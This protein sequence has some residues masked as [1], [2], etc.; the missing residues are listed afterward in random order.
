[1]VSPFTSLSHLSSPQVYVEKKEKE[2]C[3]LTFK[4]QER[5]RVRASA[6]AAVGVTHSCV[7]SGL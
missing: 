6:A 4:K 7:V 1:M 3:I 5:A 2:K